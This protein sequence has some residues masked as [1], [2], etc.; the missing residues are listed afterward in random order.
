MTQDQFYK[1]Y[2]KSDPKQPFCCFCWNLSKE[3]QA[4]IG[5]DPSQYKEL[6]NTVCTM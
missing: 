6:Q 5:H 2:Y 3:K 1:R 4:C